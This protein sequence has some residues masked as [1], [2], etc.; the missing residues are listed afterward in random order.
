MHVTK[1][2]YVHYK[3]G[4]YFVHGIATNGDTHDEK[5]AL[6][7]Y[8]A[9]AHTSAESDGTPKMRFR[10]VD[11]FTRMIDWATGLSD[12][13]AFQKGIVNKGQEIPR[14]Q[15]VVGWRDGRPLVQDPDGRD[16]RVYVF[17]PQLD[18]KTGIYQGV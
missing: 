6:V 18:N 2:Y 5:D 7:I 17:V 9:V 11:D 15:R 3:G 8:E 14:F 13:E 10:R 1:G 4:I 12:T 16:A